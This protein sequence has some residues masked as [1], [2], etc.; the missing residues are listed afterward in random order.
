MIFV[1]DKG[2]NGPFSVYMLVYG[3]RAGIDA[4]TRAFIIA[5][6]TDMF[7]CIISPAV[8]MLSSQTIR[9][10]ISISR[11]QSLKMMITQRMNCLRVLNNEEQVST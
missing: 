10:R 5:V 11:M 3:L 4:G 1:R 6:Y 8:I 2:K 9:D 7:P